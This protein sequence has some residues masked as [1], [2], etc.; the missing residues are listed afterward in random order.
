MLEEEDEED[1]EE[2]DDHVMDCD[3]SNGVADLPANSRT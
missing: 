2:E 3:A 1:R